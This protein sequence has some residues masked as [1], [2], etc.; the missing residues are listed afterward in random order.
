MTN[1]RLCYNI[2]EKEK[3]S[4]KRDIMN[5]EIVEKE[6]TLELEVWE[7][8]D[9]KKNLM[10]KSQGLL[11]TNLAN[12][13]NSMQNALF[14]LIIL[15]AK[16]NGDYVTSEFSLKDV[17]KVTNNSSYINRRGEEINKD[18]KAIKENH[19]AFCNQAFLEGSQNG[20]ALKL[21]ILSNIEYEKG[22]FFATFDTAPDKKGNRLVLELLR[23]KEVTPIIYNVE[24]FAKLSSGGQ[25]LYEHI[26]LMTYK[27]KRSC[28]VTNETLRQIFRTNGKSM[29]K[30]YTLNQIHLTPAVEDI[31]KLT[32]L[33]VVVDKIKEG[34]AVVGVELSWSIKK[35][36]AL[37]S[38]NQVRVAKEVYV[39]LVGSSAMTEPKDLALLEKLRNIHL[40]DSD[41]AFSVIKTAIKRVNA[42]KKSKA[43]PDF[44]GANEEKY[45]FDSFFSKFDGITQKHKA[46]II[47]KISIFPEKE[48]EKLLEFAYELYVQNGGR[49]IY[50]ILQT[51]IEWEFEGVEKLEDAKR[52]HLQNYGEILEKIEDID[53]SDDFLQAMDLWGK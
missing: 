38:D 25:I 52:I 35:E 46:E 42:L 47:G 17:V 29:E 8:S 48:Q 6:D 23:S 14:S 44:S 26:L 49:S 37:I 12:K 39:Q 40:L 50:Y 53:P 13:M 16:V 4:E 20:R 3:R 30:F 5:N 45:N 36:K 7:K 15:N 28:I 11:L 24:T 27:G 43:L 1:K 51:L 31:N 22:Q 34:R 19:L 18:L 21:G 10:A 2:L 41:E 33:N 32:E 9:K